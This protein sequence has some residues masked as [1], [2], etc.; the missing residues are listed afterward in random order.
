MGEFGRC[1]TRFFCALGKNGNGVYKYQNVHWRR[2]F[3]LNFGLT[4][5]KIY[6]IGK[7]IE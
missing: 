5:E 1:G 7:N 3:N 6:F 4:K 2:D